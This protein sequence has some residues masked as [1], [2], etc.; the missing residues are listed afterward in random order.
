MN[1]R[2]ATHTNTDAIVVQ[3][4]REIDVSLPHGPG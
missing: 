4:R 3:G 1:G 2:A